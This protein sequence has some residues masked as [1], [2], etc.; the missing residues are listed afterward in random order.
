MRKEDEKRISVA[1]MNWLHKIRGVSR[2][3]HI[4]NEDIRR[5]LE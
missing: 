1:E 5:Q 4:R 2:L 3:Q